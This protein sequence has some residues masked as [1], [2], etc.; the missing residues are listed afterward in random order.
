METVGISSFIKEQTQK[1]KKNQFENLSL[2]DISL[3]SQNELNQK[4][5]KIV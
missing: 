3:Y 5:Y 2:A 4:N 1:D